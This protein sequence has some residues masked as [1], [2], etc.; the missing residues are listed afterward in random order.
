[1]WKG[2]RIKF[3]FGSQFYTVYTTELYKFIHLILVGLNVLYISNTHT[4]FYSTTNGGCL[5]ISYS[6]LSILQASFLYKQ[7]YKI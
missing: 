6:N 3:Q 5:W 4:D 7:I 1:M 2:H